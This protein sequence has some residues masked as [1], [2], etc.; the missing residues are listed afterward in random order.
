MKHKLSVP[1]AP[2]QRLAGLTSTERGLGPVT[3]TQVGEGSR[4]GGNAPARCWVPPF[5]LTFTQ[6]AERWSHQ[7]YVSVPVETIHG[8]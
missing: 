6:R 5:A 2:D 4:A 1:A 8:F 3:V 7:L